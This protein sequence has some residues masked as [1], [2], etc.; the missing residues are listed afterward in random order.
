V[1]ALPCNSLANRSV[2]S[3]INPEAD[4]AETEKAEGAKPEAEEEEAK[5]P[6]YDSFYS[7]QNRDFY[8]SF[9]Y[10][11]L[12]PSDRRIRL[13][14][15]HPHAANED[16]N[17]TVECDLIDD[18][19]LEEYTGKFTTISYCAGEPN[20]TETVLVN[21][22]PF[23]AFANLGHAL[24]EA[25]HFWK[26]HHEDQELLL[27][28]DQICINQ[29]N[30]S[31]RSHQ[32]SF[33]G[34]IYAA[35]Q[36][37]LVCLSTAEDCGGG[38]TWLMQFM[39][40][41]ITQHDLIQ[42][43][44]S[45]QIDESF[46]LSGPRPSDEA[47][48]SGYQAFIGTIVESDWW[49]RA[50]VRQELL[51]STDAYF[52]ASHESL[53]FHC[54]ESGYQALWGQVCL[55]CPHKEH[56]DLPPDTCQ[57]CVIMNDMNAIRDDDLI[58]GP[59]YLLKLN[60]DNNFSLSIFPDLLHN[61]DRTSDFKAS[62]P[63]DLIY[64]CLGYSS[65]SYGLEPDYT[66]ETTFCDVSCQLARNI[67]EYKGN[68]D[69]LFAAWISRR[70]SS[71][72]HNEET[73]IPSWVPAWRYDSGG[74]DGP[75]HKAHAR[76]HVTFH[77]DDKGRSNRILHARGVL[78]R[79]KSTLISSIHRE[80]IS[81]YKHGNDELDE[82]DEVWLLQGTDHIFVFKPKGQYHELVDRVF[83]ID[84]DYRKPTGWID[85]VAKLVEENHP[86]VQTIRIC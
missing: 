4:E 61:L 54:I 33:M 58:R 49:S 34:D 27:W 53:D 82:S 71:G 13:L 22:E 59:A 25:R 52:L 23:N 63:K 21:G 80:G 9:K 42:G 76:Q 78:L 60:R 64:A 68:L 20:K 12:K 37:V 85:E 36:Q 77:S 7:P 35:A 40:D 75:G 65:H 86:A 62:D 43:I 56:A 67:I 19:S 45:V 66:P 26:T 5:E 55:L 79:A 83:K 47:L 24:R 46:K 70:R 2:H 38:M 29:K 3:D 32:V 73:E 81:T 31:E 57:V 39:S 50:W 15:L 30:T 16:D 14:R 69:I 44:H 41:M 10:E 8:E 51:R 72:E 28:A 6:K 11:T 18:V 1:I 84:G 74:F 17:A 48:L